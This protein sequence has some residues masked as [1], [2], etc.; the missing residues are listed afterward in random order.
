M[1]IEVTQEQY[2]FLHELQHEL[3]TQPTD[4]N[5]DPVFWGVM[6]EKE[7]G[8]PDGCGEPRIYL[9]DGVVN[10]LEEAVAYV[11]EWIEDGDDEIKYVWS[12]VDKEWPEDVADFIKTYIYMQCRVVWLGKKWELSDKTSAFI[13][14]RSC[15]EYIDRYGY[16]HSNP[17]TYAMTAFRN[18]EYEKL[19]NI[20]KT[21][22]FDN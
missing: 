9:G 13:T 11:N 21:I 19:I 2:N 17:H 18:P 3:L 15:Q 5:A 14:K 22:K 12:E 16:N 10:T 1:K 6:E 8:V 4:G 7:I 20:L